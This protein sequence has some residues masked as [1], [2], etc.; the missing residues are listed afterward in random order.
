MTVMA[1]YTKIMDLVDLVQRRQQN[2]YKKKFFWS[3]FR[4]K[5]VSKYVIRL[6]FFKE[7]FFIIFQD[8]GMR[9]KKVFG[10]LKVL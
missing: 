1:F 9:E 3:F 8:S 2:L 7:F 5:N 6:I 4:G 10:I